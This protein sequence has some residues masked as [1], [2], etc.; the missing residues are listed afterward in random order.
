MASLPTPI[1]ARPGWSAATIMRRPSP[2]T[3]SRL[4][5]EASAWAIASG[6]VAL[7]ARSAVKSMSDMVYLQGSENFL[8][9]GHG[10]GALEAPGDD[11]P[12]SVGKP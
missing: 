1:A 10:G 7:V 3:M 2:L 12:R 9:K 5:R 4:L 11:G 6:W 8:F